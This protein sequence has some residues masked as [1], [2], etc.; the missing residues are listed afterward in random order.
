MVEY[1]GCVFHGCQKCFLPQDVL[2]T[3]LSN[4]DAMRATE[5][6]LRLLAR[7]PEVKGVVKMQGCVWNKMKKENV[8]VQD[9]VKDFKTDRLDRR[10][11]LK[12]TFRGG[13]VRCLTKIYARQKLTIFKKN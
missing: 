2:K 11:S 5:N 4:F 10:L 12:Q 13:L 3:G 8:K 9:F 1:L 6:R 7:H